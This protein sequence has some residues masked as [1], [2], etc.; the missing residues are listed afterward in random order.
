MTC[1]LIPSNRLGAHPWLQ[2]ECNY[3]YRRKRENKKSKSFTVTLN[4]N[5]YP[6]RVAEPEPAGVATFWPEPELVE[7][8]KITVL[9]S[10]LMPTFIEV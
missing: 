2:D 6:I 1:H 8:N 4:S 3:T 7:K 10:S 9:L 5:I